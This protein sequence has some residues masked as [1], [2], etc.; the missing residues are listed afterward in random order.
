MAKAL[1]ELHALLEPDQR[2]AL[3]ELI[4]TGGI[5]F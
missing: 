2:Q 1:E 5:R 3:A 4:R